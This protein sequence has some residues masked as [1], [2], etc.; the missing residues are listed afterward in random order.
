MATSSGKYVGIDVSKDRLDIAVLG[1]TKASQ[2]GN[3]EKGIAGLIRDMK[4]LEPERIVVEATGGYQRAVVA[5]LF[6]KGLAVA[7]VNPSRVR[8]F[9]RACGLLA[10]TDKLDA[11]IL[12]VFGERVKPRLYEGKDEKER[13]LSGL[14]VRRRQLEEMI[15]AEKNRLRTI[16]PSLQASVERIIHCIQSEKKDVEDQIGVFIAGQEEWQVGRRI[17][18]SAP[19][20]GPVATATFLADLPELGKMD[21]KKIA[22]LV[23]VAPMNHDSGRKRGYRKTKGGRADVRS[24]LYMATLV[25]CRYNPTI[26]VQYENLLKRGKEKKVALT[27]CMRKFLTILNAMMRDQVPFRQ[28][29][30]V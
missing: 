1:E 22:A 23:G 20:V 18:A 21:R 10:K 8:Q 26:K 30:I 19:G 12:A 9:A 6:R 7:V 4:A 11:Q 24:V 27:A 28:R 3:D 15:K 5:G 14:L 2:T 13:E 16:Q 29:V 17:L 25:A